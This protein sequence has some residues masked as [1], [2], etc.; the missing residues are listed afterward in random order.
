[1]DEPQIDVPAFKNV[2]VVLVFT[3]LEVPEDQAAAP[4]AK[5]PNYWHSQVFRS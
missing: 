4:K 2:P 5:V 3:P 1:M